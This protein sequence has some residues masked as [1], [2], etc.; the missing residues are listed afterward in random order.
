MPWHSS[1]GT[2]LCAPTSFLFRLRK[3][4]TPDY[5]KFAAKGTSTYIRSYNSHGP[6]FGSGAALVVMAR[7]TITKQPGENFFNCYVQISISQG[8]EANGQSNDALHWGDKRLT[9]IE[10]YKVEGK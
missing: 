9:H 10:A 2:H 1:S 4:N 7:N 8:Y 6:Y 5:M 3:A